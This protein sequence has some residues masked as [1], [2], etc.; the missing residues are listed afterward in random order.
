MLL[1]SVYT[2]LEGNNVEQK[3]AKKCKAVFLNTVKWWIFSPPEPK[4]RDLIP[5]D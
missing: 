5:E 4:K 1:T 2:K 3:L